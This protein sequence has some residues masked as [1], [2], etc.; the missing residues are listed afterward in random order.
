MMPATFAEFRARIASLLAV[1]DMKDAAYFAA[2][3]D[4]NG[5][6]VIDELARAWDYMRSDAHEMRNADGDDDD[7]QHDAWVHLAEFYVHDLVLDLGGNVEQARRA[8]TLIE[9]GA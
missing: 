9:C 5:A 4:Y 2:Y 6:E 1:L 7:V 8:V 3:L